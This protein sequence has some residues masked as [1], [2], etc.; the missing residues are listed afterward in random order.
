LQ[1]Q[2]GAGPRRARAPQAVQV[3]YVAAGQLLVAPGRRHLLAADDADAVAA[4]QVL[5]ARVLRSA[6]RTESRG[7]LLCATA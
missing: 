5:R 7:G 1:A 2:R 3:E 4:R 6:G